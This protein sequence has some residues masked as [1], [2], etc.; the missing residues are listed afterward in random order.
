[1]Y[2]PAFQTTLASLI[3]LVPLNCAQTPEVESVELTETAEPEAAPAIR[4]SDWIT[5]Y[6]PQ[7]AW[8]GY[9]LAFHSQRTPV[10]L[11]MN[12]RVVHRW[13]EARIKSRARLLEDGSLLGIALG[14]GV[15]EYDWNGNEVWRY[16]ADNGFAHHDVIRLANGNTVTLIRPDDDPFDEVLE[17]DRDGDVVWRW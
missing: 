8:N 17:V 6:D 14:R 13:P 9:T 2:R 11:D 4:E 12:G 1:M 15:V 16:T 10:L 7:R 3:A 5:V